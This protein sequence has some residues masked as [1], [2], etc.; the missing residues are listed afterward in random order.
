MSVKKVWRPLGRWS[1]VLSLVH[2]SLGGPLF[3]SFGLAAILEASLLVSDMVAGGV[4][5]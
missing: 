2:L 4:D 5:S 3:G 1:K